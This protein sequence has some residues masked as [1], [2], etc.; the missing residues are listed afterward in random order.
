MKHGVESNQILSKDT[1]WYDPDILI[2][3]DMFTNKT[4]IMIFTVEG[5]VPLLCAKEWKNNMKESLENWHTYL[6]TVLGLVVI[7]QTTCS[8]A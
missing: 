5:N 8:L 7:K 6:Q 4:L 2:I 3:I 1:V